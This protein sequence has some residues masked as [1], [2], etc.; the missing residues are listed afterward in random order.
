MG[1]NPDFCSLRVDGAVSD[2]NYTIFIFHQIVF[3]RSNQKGVTQ[4]KYVECIGYV[5]ISYKTMVE[6]LKKIYKFNV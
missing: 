5:R 6:N 3:Q 1:F 4:A 2:P